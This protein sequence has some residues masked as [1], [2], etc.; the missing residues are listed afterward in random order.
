MKIKEKQIKT[1]RNANEKLFRKEEGI[2]LV[3]LVIT[4][5]IML[6][7]AGVAIATVIDGDGLFSKTRESIEVYENAMQDENDTIQS[8]M[9][10]I[11]NYLGNSNLQKADGSFD[12]TKG[13]NTPDTSAL[14]KETTKYVTWNYDETGSLYEEQLSDNAPDNWYDYDNGQWANIKTTG[15]NLE[16]YWVWIPRF[17]Y[18]LPESSTAKEIEVIFV[19]DNGKTGVLEDGTEIQCYY[20]TDVEI[21]SDRSGIYENKTADAKDK[22]IVHPAFTFGDIQLDGIWFAKF[23]PS[24]NNEN[25]EIKSYAK[26]WTNITVKESFEVCRKMQDTGGTIGTNTG[27]TSIDTHM[28]KNMEWGATAILSQSKFGIFNSESAIGINGDQTYI[29]RNNPHNEYVTGAASKEDIKNASNLDDID[30][31]KYNEGNG[32]KASTTGTVYGV[33]DMAA[34]AYE[35]VMGVTKESA[36]SDEP[37]SLYTGFEAGEW[38]EEKYYDLY[39]YC[40]TSDASTHYK[41]KIGDATSELLPQSGTTWNGNGLPSI[42]GLQNRGGVAVLLNNIISNSGI[43]CVNP[44]TVNKGGRDSFRPV[45]VIL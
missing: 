39:E 5:V 12:S 23:E 4:V 45:L 17:A 24:N 22:W 27:N 7:L 18:K 40:E 19:K 3:A 21:T 13:V 41:G 33:Y 26:S 43:F 1:N 28:A 15:N 38:P 10:E 16:A 32:P 14:P 31:D 34:G 25:V 30:C 8:L 36:T 35:R 29:V 44:N 11:D 42:T 9:N 37:K 20:S 6:I 2:T